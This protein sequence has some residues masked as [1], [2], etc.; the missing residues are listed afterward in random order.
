MLRDILRKMSKD[1]SK[2]RLKSLEQIIKLGENIVQ[3]S[4]G[5][6]KTV[7][8]SVSPPLQPLAESNPSSRRSLA[9]TAPSTERRSR[10]ANAMRKS[11]MIST[12]APV[13]RDNNYLP[14][15]T[16]SPSPMTMSALDTSGMKSIQRA[17][18]VPGLQPDNLQKKSKKVSLCIINILL[19][20]LLN[21]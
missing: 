12:P 21:I 5:K 13:H 17:T 4:E 19:S 10:S 16:P 18:K 15:F 8:R 6:K 3:E 11:E 20:F 9:D 2:V 7:R 1:D 14:D